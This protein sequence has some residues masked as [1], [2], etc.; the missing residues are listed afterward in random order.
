MDNFQLPI[1]WSCHFKHCLK[2]QT[3]Q[4]TTKH[5][6][7]LTTLMTLTLSTPAKQ[8][9][10]PSG[11]LSAEKALNASASVVC[12]DQYTSADSCV[13]HYYILKISTKLRTDFR[14]EKFQGRKIHGLRGWL[15]HGVCYA[16]LDMWGSTVV[17]MEDPKIEP[18]ERL[19]L[20]HCGRPLIALHILDL[21]CRIVKISS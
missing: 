6:N 18:K 2:N 19:N 20:T 16:K 1:N 10:A 11:D 4:E 5:I 9:P 14:G 7:K 15:S 8:R 12:H 17:Y 13:A 3:V 21:E